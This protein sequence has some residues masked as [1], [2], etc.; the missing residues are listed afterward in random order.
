MCICVVQ[1]LEAVFGRICMYIREATTFHTCRVSIMTGD[2][3]KD[4]EN[5]H[6]YTYHSIYTSTRMSVLRA[7]NMSLRAKHFTD[8]AS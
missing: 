8:V 6:T 1:K 7:F 3:M 5:S 4:N 2:V